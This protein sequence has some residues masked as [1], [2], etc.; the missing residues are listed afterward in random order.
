M[1]TFKKLLAMLLA[2]AM[3]FA[4]AACELNSSDDDDDDKKSK[5]EKFLSELEDLLDEILEAIE[6]GDQEKEEE[7]YEKLEDMGDEYEDILEELEEDDEEKAEDFEKDFEKLIEKFEED[8]EELENEANNG[9]DFEI[10]R[11][12]REEAVTDTRAPDAWDEPAPTETYPVVEEMYVADITGEWSYELDLSEAFSA[13]LD[14]SAGVEVAPDNA[15][16]MDVTLDFDSNGRYKMEMELDE[17]SAEDYYEALLLNMVDLCETS[18]TDSGS[19]K[20]EFEAQ[21][22]MTLYEYCKQTMD[23]V[24]DNAMAS[25]VFETVSGYYQV[26]GSYI[27][28]AAYK[29]DLGNWEN[30]MEFSVSGYY[31]TIY[32]L[33]ENGEDVSDAGNQMG[34][35]MPWVFTKD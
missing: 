29:S 8:V 2:L 11:P 33:V 9:G 32:K 4:M 7:L 14:A 12:Q 20:A 31:L 30:Y 1:K 13:S 5:E 10:G 6:D 24:W 17:D 18:L 16:Y 3:V 26:D 34:M 25:F 15:L 19:S 35:T 23:E 22:G 28:T 27:H 21:A